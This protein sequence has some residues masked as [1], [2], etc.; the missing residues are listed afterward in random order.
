MEFEFATANRIV[1]GPGRFKQLAE[2]AEG[3]G[4]NALVV[5]GKSAL[6]SSGLLAELVASLGDHQVSSLHFIVD[7]EPT[8]EM[9]EG[10][11]EMA[12]QEKANLVIAI[13]GGSV[14]DSG[15][16]I[17]GLLTNS[18]TLL[19]HMEVVG[20]GEPLTKS[21]APL[22]AVPTTSGTG[23]E[24]TRNAVIKSEEH[25]VKASLRSPFLLPTVALVD[26][27]L[28][29]SLPQD[30]T[31]STGLDALTQVIEPFTSNRAQPMTDSICRE[32][33]MRA[34]RSLGRV[35]E[36]GSDPLAR[37]DMAL[38]SLFGGLALANSGLGAVHGFAGSLGGMYPISH[39]IIC[40]ALLP[41]VMSANVRAI[42]IKDPTSPLL[43]K[44]AEVGEILAGKKFSKR[45]E[46]IEAAVGF[47][48]N[49]CLEM[50]IKGLAEYGVK[51]KDVQEAAEKAAK[52]SSMKANPVV[53]TLEE[54]DNILK[55]AL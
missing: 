13:G 44:Y 16:A 21:A 4:N 20:Q 40:A 52:A 25:N 19:D 12:R 14:L 51:E 2:I 8:V 24:V 28:T 31:A 38:A 1:F 37:E 33:M 39:G 18:G 47:V 45:V 15:K 49:I 43:L 54:L 7:S 32:G 11:L 55:A 23:S 3:L 22:I 35:Y 42:S 53:F 6:E 50:N 48:Q 34:A 9:L 46:A 26:P 17:A 36:D 5:T 10:G 29:H 41:H 27:E 30:I